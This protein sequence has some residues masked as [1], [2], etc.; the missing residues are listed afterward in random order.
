MSNV[1]HTTTAGKDVTQ[2]VM[3]PSKTQYRNSSLPVSQ[4]YQQ[5]A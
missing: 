1:N 2:Y 3:L 4:M 5:L